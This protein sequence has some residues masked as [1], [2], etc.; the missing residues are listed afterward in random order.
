MNVL[1]AHHAKDPDTCRWVIANCDENTDNITV[2][3]WLEACKEYLA[4]LDIDN[5]QE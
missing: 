1:C 3:Q 2:R 5:K 4:T